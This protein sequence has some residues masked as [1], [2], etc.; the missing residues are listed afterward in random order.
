MGSGHRGCSAVMN[1]R[2]VERKIARL[3]CEIAEIDDL[4]KN[5]IGGRL[6][7]KGARQA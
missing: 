6:D 3:T 7:P 5:D 1:P 2:F 4:L